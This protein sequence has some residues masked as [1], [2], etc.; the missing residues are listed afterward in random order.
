MG[1]V[2]LIPREEIEDTMAGFGLDLKDFSR[3]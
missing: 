1:I 3:P 2:D